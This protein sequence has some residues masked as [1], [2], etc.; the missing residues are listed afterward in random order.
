[1]TANKNMVSKI[2][3]LKKRSDFLRLQRDGVSWVSKHLVIQ[4][5]PSEEG[6]IRLG[7]TVSKKVSSLAVIRNRIKRRLREVARQVLPNH[8]VDSYD[9]VL[10]GRKGADE[11]NFETLIKEL[12][13]CLNKL[14]L[15]KQ[16]TK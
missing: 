9:F 12:I 8:A 7:L 2:D 1:M 3:R 4:A 13:W 15:N 14:N 10:I 6:T 16:G 11:V 5:A